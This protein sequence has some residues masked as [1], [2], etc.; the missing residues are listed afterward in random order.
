MSKLFAEKQ[1]EFF[2]NK[3]SLNYIILRFD[4]IYGYDQNM[5]G[6]LEMCYENMSK[7]KDV[8]LFN[9][10]KQTRDQVYIDDA[11]NSILLSIKKIN[12]KKSGIYNVG[13]G[14]P[15]SNIVLSKMLRYEL[16]SNSNIIK[17]KKK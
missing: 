10:G 8:E 13:G 16:K 12:L 6:F 3:K 17:L 15:I 11:V 1:I 4:G 7:N 14:N 9:F 2:A 5:P